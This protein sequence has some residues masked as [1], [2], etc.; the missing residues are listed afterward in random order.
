[1]P[2]EY[3]MQPDAALDR[4][5]DQVTQGRL[6]AAGNLEPADAAAIQRLHRF[7]DRPVPDPEFK[8]RLREELTQKLAV[9][10]ASGPSLSV[11]PGERT[12]AAWPAMGPN[13][14]PPRWPRA[15]LP[16][17]MAM[18][19]IIGLLVLLGTRG[20]WR[21]SSPRVP[22]MLSAIGSPAATPGS[23]RPADVPIYRADP[24][25]TG[26]MPGPG[27]TSAPGQL[28]RIDVELGPAA[29]PAIVQGV[30]YVAGGDGLH[31]FDMA[32]GN[33][34]WHSLTGVAISSSPAVVEDVV[35]SGSD[36]GVLYAIAADS[37]EVHWVFPGTDQFA[38]PLVA[39][40][41]VYVGG[42][43]GV[44]HALDAKTGAV[45]WQVALNSAA[46]E[47][48][49]LAN[50]LVYV[51]S[52]DGTLHAIDATTGVPRWQFQ[53]D[54]ASFL[55]PVVVGDVIFQA[56]IGD[57]HN[58]VYALDA[59]TGQE[60]W[61]VNLPSGDGFTNAVAVGGGTV[62]V[63]NR[64]GALYALDAATGAER[65]HFAT[66]DLLSAA[67]ALVGDTLYVADQ[68]SSLYALDAATGA[69]R[70][71]VSLGSP[72]GYGPVVTGGVIYAGTNSG[73]VYALGDGGEPLPRVASSQGR[74][75]RFLW[76]FPGN[77][78][79]PLSD[80][81]DLE[82]DPQ[83]RLW[84]TDAGNGRF[85]I[86]SPAGDYLE[87][88]GERGTGDGQFNFVREDGTAY[89]GI[90]FASDGGFYVLDTGNQRVQQFAP[91]RTFVRGW[92]GKGDADGQFLD[93]IG[94]DLGSEGTVFVVD[95]QRHDIQ[96]FASDGQWLGV[97]DDSHLPH[98][99]TFHGNVLA[100]D[101]PGHLY[102]A[103]ADT[104]E[105]EVFDQTGA[106]IRA[107]GAENV[108]DQPQAIAVDGLGRLFVATR[109]GVKVFDR[110]GRY[111]A[112]WAVFGLG[113]DQLADPR[114]IVVN[115]RDVYLSN[116]DGNRIEKFRL[117]SLAP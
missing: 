69:E 101:A 79:S 33:E 81:T 49:A 72:I 70:W 84:V 44:F 7:D 63:P 64:N 12:R 80:P 29:A 57:E 117:L 20:P 3:D 14:L 98:A 38:S 50:G 39:N 66:G 86:F 88:W 16:M 13:V 52:A 1:M 53:P 94:M 96:Q 103:N 56:M 43:D 100:S 58:T 22:V 59:E 89:G 61:S 78:M 21:W 4:F 95:D 102:V 74:P 93:P 54:L 106:L 110:D 90:E 87:S 112:E 85:Q 108:E 75:A 26:Q 24:A 83:G 77:P 40:G 82:I 11:G 99:N 73:K 91:D 107:I 31:A 48:P 2:L 55:P 19:L 116:H 115:E 35:Y 105:I 41:T 37:G 25:R 92:G 15:L 5:W 47:S 17:A 51:G 113:P 60:R 104:N 28:W 36:T 111:L 97:I 9:P 10:V 67:P 71:R 18:L 65:W 62:F 114:G 45:L 27:P 46:S 30:L 23:S 6:D 68:D 32:S 76:E 34:R 109:S 42:A 8:R